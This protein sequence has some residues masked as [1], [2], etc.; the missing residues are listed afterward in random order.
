[1]IMHKRPL[2]SL[3]LFLEI[4]TVQKFLFT[5]SKGFMN[6][7]KWLR[8]EGS[9]CNAFI[10]RANA[11]SMAPESAML[12]LILLCLSKHT[13]PDFFSRKIKRNN[14]AFQITYTAYPD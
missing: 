13:L 8:A 14:I 2:L 12:L 10:I 3:G 9:V 11:L 5:L 4:Y 7:Q 1:M 6:Y